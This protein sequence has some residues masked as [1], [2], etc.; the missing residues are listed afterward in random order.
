MA[1][2]RETILARLLVVAKAIP[3][4][5]TCERNLDDIGDAALP[6]IILFDGDEEASENMKA[7]G[8]APNT[9][10]MLPS[11]EIHYGDVPENV[12]TTANEWRAKLIKAILSDAALATS[13]GNIPNAGARYVRTTTGLSAGRNAI[14]KQTVAFGIHYSFKPSAL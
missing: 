6:A 13:C 4:V 7:R 2:L 14:A 9:V 3:G 10:E 12:G 11:F 5:E 1:D 8:L